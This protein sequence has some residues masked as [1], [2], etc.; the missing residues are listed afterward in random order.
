MS[1]ILAKFQRGHPQRGRQVEVGYV[2]TAIFDQY[3]AI[4][5]TA[6]NRDIVSISC[7]GTLIGT[8]NS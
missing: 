8:P 5:Q 7:Y 3:L 4:S 1:K 2:K 6:Q